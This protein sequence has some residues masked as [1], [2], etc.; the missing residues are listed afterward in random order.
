MRLMILALAL[1][2]APARAGDWTDAAAGPAYRAVETVSDGVYGLLRFSLFDPLLP[3]RLSQRLGDAPEESSYAGFS[4]ELKSREERAWRA[5][6]ESR[7]LGE[8]ATPAAVSDWSRRTFRSETSAAGD[9]LAQSLAARYQIARFGRD[10][11]DFAS[12]F[13]NWDAD[14]LASAALFGGAYV[15]LAGLRADWTAGPLLVALD[16]KPGSAL[17]G[18]IES[19]ECAGLAS[20]R[21]SP[22]GSPFSLRTDWGVHGARLAS[23]RVGLGY[24]LAF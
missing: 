14:F 20:L 6:L 19:G 23:E 17:R 11:G 16:V 24:S 21:L 2:A 3:D 5:A 10:S 18:Q 4:V 22:R 13:R 8:A 15:Y 1:A 12:D 9:A 7:P